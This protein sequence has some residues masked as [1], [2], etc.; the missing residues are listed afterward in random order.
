LNKKPALFHCENDAQDALLA[1]IKST[2]FWHVTG[3]V[4]VVKIKKKS[5]KRGRR[6]KN[7]VVEYDTF[8]KVQYE[9]TE[10][11]TEIKC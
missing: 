9:I 2:A 5:N 7:A 6:P 10:N 4:Q 11:D 3:H 1:T 8:Y